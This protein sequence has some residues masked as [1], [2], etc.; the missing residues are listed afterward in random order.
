MTEDGKHQGQVV[1]YN[2]RKG[3]GFVKVGGEIL[4]HL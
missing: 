2:E 4:Q 3:Y 1:W